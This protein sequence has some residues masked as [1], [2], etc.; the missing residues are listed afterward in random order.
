MTACTAVR[1]A[2]ARLDGA[3]HLG[4][5]VARDDDAALGAAR[6]L[7]AAPSPP[8]PLAGLPITVKDWIDVAG[9]PCEGESRVRTGRVPTRDATAVARL[10]AAGAVVVAKTQ[11]GHEH[12]LHGVCRHPVDAARTPGGSST[13]EAVLVAAG[14]SVLG[15]GSDSG[16]SVRLPAA[17]CGVA[18]LKPTLGRVPATGH[19]PRV[20]GHHDGRTVLGPLAA[21]VDLLAVALRVMAGPDGRDWTCAPAPVESPAAVTLEGLRVAVLR[22]DAG[23]AP[24]TATADAVEAAAASLGA[25]GAVVLEGVVP[26]H[27]D[28][29]LDLT[30]R[31][32][33]REESTGA[34]VD[35]QLADWDAFAARLGA[36]GD[37]VDV[38]LG[39]TVRDVA[40]L[41][42]D[43]V[44]EDYV[45]TLPWSLTGWPAVSLPAGADPATGLPLAVQ[46]AAPA[47]R[48][49]VALAVAG[50]LERDGFVAGVA[51]S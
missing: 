13:G 44:P 46:V 12:P 6:A 21:R 2:L 35:R 31:Y 22:G 10:R 1:A 14:A 34:E 51:P 16:G 23:W 17:W 28:E 15:L 37:E 48:D 33:G 8:G 29:A 7:D 27:L 47:W 11:P 4:A 18:A 40:P 41:R 42:R 26:P 20:G 38:V 25:R 30:L 39:P 3:A 5:V 49:H 32:W 19:H 36:V 9:L 50:A 45:H 43:L 24:A